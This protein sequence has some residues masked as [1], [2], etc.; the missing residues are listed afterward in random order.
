MASDSHALSLCHADTGTVAGSTRSLNFRGE[1][2]QVE[3]AGI[4]TL[5]CQAYQLGMAHV[6]V[7]NVMIDSK[8]PLH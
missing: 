8:M 7:T 2:S 6:M 4:K 1:A 5:L 3:F